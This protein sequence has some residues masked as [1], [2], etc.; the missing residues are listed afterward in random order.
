MHLIPTVLQFSNMTELRIN[1]ISGDFLDSMIPLKF[2]MYL[3]PN[4]DW[5]VDTVKKF[6]LIKNSTRLIIF[7]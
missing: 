2:Y 5:P 4:C 3:L 6:F 7:I 1:C